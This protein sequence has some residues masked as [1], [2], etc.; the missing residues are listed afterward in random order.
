ME[1]RTITDEYRRMQQ[2]LHQNPNYG[3]ASL[4]FAPLVADL[5]RQANVRSVS[6]Y[7]AGKKNLLKGLA[8]AG[9]QGILY[10]PYDP[11]FPEYGAPQ[12]ADLVCCIDVLEHIEPELVDNVLTELARITTNLGLFSIHMGPAAKV[13]S[14]GRNAHLIQKPSSWWLPRLTQHFEILQLQTHNTMGHGIWVIVKPRE[15]TG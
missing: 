5:I 3:V 12:P 9:I 13:L 7:G 15:L 14:D 8:E 6:D 2:E 1:A 10:H 4:A 11:A